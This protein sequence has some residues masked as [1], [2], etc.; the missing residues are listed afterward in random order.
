MYVVY[1]CFGDNDALLY[2]GIT[3]DVIQRMIAHRSLPAPWFA[4]MRRFHARHFR[5][6]EEAAAA[7]TEAIQSLHPRDNIDRSGR[8]AQGWVKVVDRGRRRRFI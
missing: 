6:R 3:A 5:T 1:Y 8:S 2:V 4:D 7:E